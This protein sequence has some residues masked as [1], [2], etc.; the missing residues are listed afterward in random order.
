[1]AI[2]INPSSD[3]V[4]CFRETF[5]GRDDVVP[6]YH[7]AKSSG[8]P[9]YSPICKNKFNE[10][11]CLIKK[12]VKKPCDKCS[13]FIPVPLTDKLIKG[14]ILSTKQVDILGV[15]PL[16][17]NGACFFIAGDFDNHTGTK[18][19]LRDVITY[20]EV[21]SVQEIPCYI[22]KSKSGKGYHCYIFFRKSVPA[23]KA[24]A[25]AF[26]ILQ[27]AG[28]IND[29]ERLSSFDRLFP[30]QSRLSGKKLGNLIALPWQGPAIPKGNTVFL[31]PETGFSEP[32]QDQI[33]VLKNIKKIDESAL[34]R[35]ISD[36][37]LDINKKTNPKADKTSNSN[38]DYPPAT[39]SKIKAG[40][41][42]MKHGE[43]DAAVLPEPEWYIVLSVVTRCKNGQNLAH[44]LSAPHPN[45][46][47]EETN[48]K[49]EQALNNT[50]PYT[51]DEI[52]KINQTYCKDCSYQEKVKSPIV[53][54]LRSENKEIIDKKISVLNKKHFV[55]MLGGK[56]VVGNE[57]IDPALNRPDITF[58]SKSDLYNF[59]ANDIYIDSKKNKQA[60]IADFWWKSR[61]RRQYEGIIFAPGEDI[62]GYYNLWKGFSVKPKKGDWSLYRKHIQNIIASGNKVWADWIVAWMARVV[63]DPGG[64]RPGTAIV[65][66][67]KQGTGKGVFV[68]IYGSLFGGHYLQ[69]AHASHV[70]GRF[71]SHLKDAV[72]V[73]VD[74]G[75]WGGDKQ[76]EGII[77]NMVTEPFI[78]VE[79]KGKDLI[80]VQNHVNIIIVSNNQWVIP[81]G[82]EERRFFVLD[83][84][85]DRQQD[86]RYFK[87][88]V[89]QMNNGG[90][91]ALLYDLLNMDI[92]GIDLRTVERTEGLLDQIIN[93]MTTVQKYWFERLRDGALSIKSFEWENEIP[94]AIQYNEYLSF[95]ETLKDRYPK[96]EQQFGRELKKMCKGIQKQRVRREGGGREF[97]RYFP[98]LSACRNQFENLVN[99]SIDWEEKYEND[100]PF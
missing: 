5:R 97:V 82:L 98:S 63:Q 24:R 15:Y 95:A 9:G 61:K 16:L 47:K 30:N 45:Y 51:C 90:R 7:R 41:G 34:D 66:R 20:Y 55:L 72:V 14:H 89:E 10:K 42:F 48:A 74:E 12:G 87:A 3:I 53:I 37:N 36:W 32:Y 64:E 65:L 73:F 8:K 46:T 92:S 85:E 26:A 68:N 56:C 18:D 93:S 31:D 29:S 79:Q 99:M 76:A 17:N 28:V 44:R 6:Q 54:G 60:S 19:P 25:V 83:I 43:K 81:A 69:I 49:I 27:E 78:N 40:C 2:R 59:Y 23:W 91:E 88:I 62:P 96:C 4:K 77:K 94:T 22:L 100:V 58:S 1:M 38:Q 21:C 39:W 50:G 11:L 70:T 84:S 80:R 57:T 67:G 52:K 33:E 13:N 86:H 75:F 35:L 71:N